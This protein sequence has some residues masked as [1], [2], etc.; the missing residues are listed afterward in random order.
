M[1]RRVLL[2]RSGAR[3]DPGHSFLDSSQ[4]LLRRQ[5]V[6]HLPVRAVECDL[7]PLAQAAVV[8]L[9]ASH[10][11][12]RAA[13]P[14]LDLVPEAVVVVPQAVQFRVDRGDRVT[15]IEPAALLAPH[16][17][18][19]G[20]QRANQVCVKLLLLKQERSQQPEQRPLRGAPRPLEPAAVF[21]EP[22]RRHLVE[23]R[24]E[25]VERKELVLFVRQPRVARRQRRIARR[26]R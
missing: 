10:P 12:V 25:R 21:A 23:M 24:E 6:L 16:P 3:L 4:L 1:G 17:L 22:R 13:Q 11:L 26:S 18:D 19:G 5:R 8:F 7:Q 2:E 20:A 15:Q 14:R 9:D